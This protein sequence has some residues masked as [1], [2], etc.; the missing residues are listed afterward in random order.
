MPAMD[1][2]TPVIVATGQRTYHPGN[3]T[4]ALDLL[5]QAG[6]DAF[7]DAA[8]TGSL[9]AAID[10][11]WVVSILS[12]PNERAATELAARLG[13][14]DGD[15]VV[16]TIGG[17]SPQSLLAA[18]CDAIAAGTLDAVLIGG[19]EAGA[20]ARRRGPDDTPT[21]S[22]GPADRVVGD[23]RMG[24]TELEI[25]AGLAGPPFMYPIFESALAAVARRSIDDQQRWLGTFCAPMSAIA[26][27]RPELAWFPTAYEPGE[28]S[29]ATT[30]NRMIAAPYTKRM[31]SIIAVDQAAAVV[32]M[33]AGTAADLG[34]ARDRWVFP[35]SAGSCTEVFFASQ[36]PSLDH[37]VAIETAG[38][39]ALAAAG[40]GIDDIG[41]VDLY[42][43]FPV[44]MQMAANALGLGVEDPTRLTLTGSMPYFG[45]PGNNYATHGIACVVDELRAG[46]SELGLATGL[47]WYVTKHAV[48]IYGSKPPPN[49]WR[50]DRCE[51]AQADIDATALP[52]SAAPS[53][54]AVIEGHTTVFER[55]GSPTAAPAFARLPTG[56][57]A[58]L[59]GS[60]EVAVALAGQ[61]LV[62][63][64]VNVVPATPVAA[65]EPVD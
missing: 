16:S 59:V 19:A 54:T 1:P 6:E 34:I 40:V 22:A 30:D 55:D 32:V 41:A 46:R 35:W 8:A 56:E 20:S 58:V 23:A 29:R 62:G 4:T 45:G 33:A 2:R 65:F 12:D 63:R 10:A 9:R 48:G 61:C 51:K 50:S 64:S 13:V 27:Q 18:A 47:G 60:A 5:S 53:G 52:V 24:A 15:R 14:G 25:A 49:G 38:R 3:P 36:R 43:C 42:S 7:A 44:A 28:I 39:A 11:V 17:N 26:A 57:R 21:A 31:N 37:S